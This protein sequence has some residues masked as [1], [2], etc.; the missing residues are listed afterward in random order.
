MLIE[1]MVRHV[2]AVGWVAIA[3][4]VFPLGLYSVFLGLGATRFFQRQSVI[5]CWLPLAANDSDEQLASSTHTRSI[6]LLGII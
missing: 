6:P 4:A 2:S 5:P 3:A 1:R